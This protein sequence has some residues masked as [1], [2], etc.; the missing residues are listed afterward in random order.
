MRPC[1]RTLCTSPLHHMSRNSSRAACSER[2]R[3]AG[4]RTSSGAQQ[5]RTRTGPQSTMP[6]RTSL[7][8]RSSCSLGALC[9][10]TPCILRPVPRDTPQSWR[11]CARPVRR[12]DCR[13]RCTYIFRCRRARR[14]SSP[15]EHR[16]RPRAP[17]RCTSCQS[18]HTCRP[19]TRLQTPGSRMHLGS[20]PP[21]TRR[22][23]RRWRRS[24][25]PAC[26]GRSRP[27]GRSSSS[28]APRGRTCR[29]PRSTTAGRTSRCQVL[30]SR[31]P[32][33]WGAYCCPKPCMCYRGRLG[34][35]T[36]YHRWSPPSHPRGRRSR[37]RGT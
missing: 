17:C 34:S 27:A 30:A 20:S 15:E 9:S 16:R 26:P 18:T 29:G 5:G 6:A 23:C 3:Q 4:T 11:Q 12:T 8:W 22:C 36:S 1:T 28:G 21:S 13:R 19:C 24:S 33:T 7:A 2:W 37:C 14:H 10:P 31:P 32:C 35:R 25:R